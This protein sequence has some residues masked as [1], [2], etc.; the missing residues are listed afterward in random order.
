MQRKVS[1]TKRKVLYLNPTEAAYCIG[2]MRKTGRIAGHFSKLRDRSKRV[3]IGEGNRTIK[4][5]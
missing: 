2:Q 3:A 4:Y 1:P 5:V